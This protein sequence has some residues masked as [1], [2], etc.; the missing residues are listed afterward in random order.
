MPILLETP[1]AEAKEV[2]M[3]MNLWNFGIHLSDFLKLEIH[4]IVDLS[5]KAVI[6]IM[7][8]VQQQYEFKSKVYSIER[9]EE[10]GFLSDFKRD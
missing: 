4:N 7:V 6:L 9:G 2:N 8:L 3:K 1:S 10:R 5:G